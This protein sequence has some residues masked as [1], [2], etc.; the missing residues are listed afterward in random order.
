MQL[1]Y[2][3]SS[4]RIN[5]SQLR[6]SLCRYSIQSVNE[7]EGCMS[8]SEKTVRCCTDRRGEDEAAMHALIVLGPVS[9]RLLG[10]TGGWQGRQAWREDIRDHR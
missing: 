5:R 8:M 3:P 10:F 4:T 9:A 1:A 2:R 7:Y 6:Y